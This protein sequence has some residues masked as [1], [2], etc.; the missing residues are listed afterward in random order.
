MVP[1]KHR[2]LHQNH[3]IT[4]VN[5]VYIDNDDISQWQSLLTAKWLQS[6][7]SVSH[8]LCTPDWGVSC[9]V[10]RTTIC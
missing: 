1:D 6:C 2:H 3:Q 5:D 10:H 9:L 8:I 4:T 7:N